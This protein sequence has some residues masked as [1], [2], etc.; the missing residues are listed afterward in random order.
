MSRWNLSVFSW[1]GQSG[2]LCF[3]RRDPGLWGPPTPELS[4]S[5]D[6]PTSKHFCSLQYWQRLRVTLLIWQFLSRWQVYTM[7]FWMLRRKK[8][9]SAGKKKAKAERAREVVRLCNVVRRGREFEMF[10]H[11]PQSCI[12][13]RTFH[14]RLL[15]LEKPSESL[16]RTTDPFTILAAC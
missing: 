7:F 10:L 11:N 16:L 14:C 2:D 12:S 8:P 9:W 13:L 5:L 1:V 15:R 4:P 3:V 6:M